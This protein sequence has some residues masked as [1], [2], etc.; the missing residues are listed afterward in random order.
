MTKEKVCGSGT[1]PL[2]SDHT[3]KTDVGE[4]PLGLVRNVPAP[5]EKV[6]IGYST[7]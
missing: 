6:I 3:A 5:S 7:E 2:A 1:L 4:N